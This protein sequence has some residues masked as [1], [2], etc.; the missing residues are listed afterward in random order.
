M[1][2]SSVWPNQ[3]ATVRVVGRT[4]APPSVVLRALIVESSSTIG[5]AAVPAGADDDEV[6]DEEVLAVELVELVELVDE[7]VLVDVLPDELP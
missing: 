1:C 7:D 6:L 4:V 2:G 5:F 3:C